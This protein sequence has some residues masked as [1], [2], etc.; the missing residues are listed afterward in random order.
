DGARRGDRGRRARRAHRRHRPLRAA[1][2]RLARVA[3]LTRRAARSV[4]AGDA[5]A[6][7]P[8]R[9][10]RGS[11]GVPG[12]RLAEL[13]L[14][15]GLEADALEEALRAVVALLVDDVDVV[16]V[17]FARLFQHRV[18]GEAADTAALVVGVHVDAP[19]HGAEV[20]LRLV[21]VEVRADEPD[22]LVP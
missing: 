5:A 1:A 11:E 12:D 7:R 13:R 8:R 6:N 20:L 14:A 15:D 3:R 16:H 4:G 10:R 9:C 19:E 22:D 17:A 2:R 18:D 21:R